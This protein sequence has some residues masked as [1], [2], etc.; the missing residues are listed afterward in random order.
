VSETILYLFAGV[1]ILA[2]LRS[3]IGIV[4]KGFA[5]LFNSA[6]PSTPGQRP[7]TT[8]LPTPEALKKDPVCGT[9]LPASSAVQ[10]TIKGQTYYFCSAECRDKFKGQAETTRSAERS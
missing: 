5:D 3:V 2:V 7:P 6:S 9:F 10:K 4:L 8:T 1:L